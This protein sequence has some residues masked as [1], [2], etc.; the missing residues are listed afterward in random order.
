MR[1]NLLSAEFN[2][3]QHD[4]N[5]NSRLFDVDG[6]FVLWIINVKL[7]IGTFQLFLHVGNDVQTSD[8]ICWMIKL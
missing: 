6:W 3:Q 7:R 4:I 1:L 2:S 5:N 8:Y